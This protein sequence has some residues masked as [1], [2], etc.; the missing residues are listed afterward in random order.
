MSGDFRQFGEAA[1]LYAKYKDVVDRMQKAYQD[2]VAA[3][4]DALDRRVKSLM[5]PREIRQKTW[6]RLY[7]NW[8]LADWPLADDKNAAEGP[9]ASLWLDQT[10]SRIVSPGV[11][12]ITVW[13]HNKRESLLQQV[14]SVRSQLT[15]PPT[16]KVA[17]ADEGGVGVGGDVF[18]VIVP[19]GEDKD[20]VA[21]AA[22]PIVHMLKLM[23]GAVGKD[24][25]AVSKVS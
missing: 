12:P 11:L 5:Q 10:S 17:D 8:W 9:A 24:A 14:A 15:L 1:R 13:V 2:D 25:Q 21:C 7:Y 16:C 22:E 18:T 4:L 20:P 19:Y 3:F 23:D 6:N